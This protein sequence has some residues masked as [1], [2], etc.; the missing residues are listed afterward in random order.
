M[1]QV[2]VDAIKKLMQEY[3][4]NQ[5]SLGKRIGV[6]RACVSRILK[7]KRSPSTKFIAGFKQAFP[8]HSLEYYFFIQSVADRCHQDKKEAS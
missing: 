4:L 1:F 2:N 5:S 8:M 3:N 6:S 7:G